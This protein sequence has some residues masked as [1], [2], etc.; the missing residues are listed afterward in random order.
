MQMAPPM[1]RHS[2]PPRL[3]GPTHA[4]SF[5]FRRLNWRPVFERLGATTDEGGSRFQAAGDLDPAGGAEAK[6]NRAG[7][8]NPLFFAALATA[9][10]WHE[11]E[12]SL[13]AG[14]ER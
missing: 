1:E 4:S 7:L 9:L 13:L 14:P 2:N 3:W 8:G 12:K 11:H 6:F 5:Q 10:H